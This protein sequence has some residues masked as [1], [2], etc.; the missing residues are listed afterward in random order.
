MYIAASYLITCAPAMLTKQVLFADVSL[1][2]CPRKILKTT[3]QKL[4]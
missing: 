3:D 2:V 4:M 1:Y